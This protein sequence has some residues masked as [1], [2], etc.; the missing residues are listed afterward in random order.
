MSIE[1]KDESPVVR[2]DCWMI[3]NHEIMSA[4]GSSRQGYVSAF[5]RYISPILTLEQVVYSMAKE[6][7]D[8]FYH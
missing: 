1:L 4:L 3:C 5:R 8:R 2:R 6:M 7:F